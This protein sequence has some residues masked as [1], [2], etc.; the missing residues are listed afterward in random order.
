MKMAFTIK[1]LLIWILLVIAP[2]LLRAQDF[3]DGMKLF[4]R[5]EYD[6]LIRSFIPQFIQDHPEEE[7]LAR[8]FLGES[9][10]NKALAQSNLAR[11]SRL[12]KQAYSEFERAV[13]REDLRLAPSEYYYSAGY[14]M[15]WCSYRLAELNQDPA[16]MLERAFTHFTKFETETADSIKLHSNYMAGNSALRLSLLKLYNPLGLTSNSE[17]L[18]EITNALLEAEHFYDEI[19]NHEQTPGTPRNLAA[20][21][22]VQFMTGVS[23]I[24]DVIPFPRT[25][26]NAEF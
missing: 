15:G 26:K 22:T 18:S 4:N 17:S 1:S 21:R 9:Y 19:L 16:E 11:S 2:C 24:R 13:S 14:K 23:N 7:G 25:P 8:Y 6:T 20:L 12:L 10:Y 5:A 3:I